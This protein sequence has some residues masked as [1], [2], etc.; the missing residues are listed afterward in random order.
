RRGEQRQPVARRLV[1]RRGLRELLGLPLARESSQPLTPQLA[2]GAVGDGTEPV[3]QQGA[4]ADRARLADE[5]QEGGLEGVV[6]VRP[7]AEEAWRSGAR[8]GTRNPPDSVP[9][10]IVLVF[11]TPRV[12]Q[13]VG[14]VDE[15]L[16]LR[17]VH[18]EVQGRGKLFELQLVGKTRRGECL[19]LNSCDGE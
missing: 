5:D 11:L 15:G 1:A 14:G 7:G 13:G 3:S 2:G 19:E 16:T 18:E 8:A 6:G 9:L 4:A 12:F 17:R 10:R